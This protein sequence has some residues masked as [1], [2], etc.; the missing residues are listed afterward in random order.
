[1]AKRKPQATSTTRTQLSPERILDAALEV[2]EG[3]G[4]DALSMRRLAEEL[5]VWPMAVYRYFRD[6]EELL[7]AI[8]DAAAGEVPAPDGSG[9]WR[10]EIGELLAGARSALRRYT[11]TGIPVER[12]LLT[13]SGLRM[14]EAGVG[15]LAHAGLEPDEAAR[16][17]RALFAYAVGAPPLTH[18][19]S[20]DAIEY[21]LERLL[22]GL[23]ARMGARA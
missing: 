12:V 18:T 10:E 22:D 13:S 1:M 19:G 4:L 6:K 3:E 15:I 8:V 11:G 17:W 16:A 2:V 9:S 7:E 21:G 20:D 5:D 14:S 23:E